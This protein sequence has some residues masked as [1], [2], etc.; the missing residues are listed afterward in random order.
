MQSVTSASEIAALGRERTVEGGKL[1]PWWVLNDVL[2]E[3]PLFLCAATVVDG[4]VI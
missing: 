1:V 2:E 3:L 4:G